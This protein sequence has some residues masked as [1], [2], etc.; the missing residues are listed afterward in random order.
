MY[1]TCKE[2]HS[3]VITFLIPGQNL[4]GEQIHSSVLHSTVNEE[5][6]R[7][8]EIY[9][10]WQVSSMRLSKQRYWK[11]NRFMGSDSNRSFDTC[12]KATKLSNKPFNSKAE[13]SIFK[14][15][16][17]WGGLS[18]YLCFKIHLFESSVFVFFCRATFSSPKQHHTLSSAQTSPFP[19]LLKEQIITNNRVQALLFLSK[20][21]RQGKANRRRFLCYK[22]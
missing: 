15:S 6:K 11:A 9:F 1:F 5:I 13:I 4:T 7:P 19:C 22:M 17:G 18:L 8:I 16:R 14:L 10:P 3:A 20:S 21:C 2:L 12:R